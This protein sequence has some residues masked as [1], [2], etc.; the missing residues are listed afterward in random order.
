MCSS[1]AA[2]AA[3]L[4]HVV[5]LRET[6]RP[7]LS[8]VPYRREV[9]IATHGSGGPCQHKHCPPPACLSTRARWYVLCTRWWWIWWSW[10]GT[11][12]ADC[13]GDGSGDGGGGG[14]G[15]GSDGMMV[16]VV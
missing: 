7:A 4:P 16:A 13:G 12:S 11:W 3:L 5:A 15:D 1:S 6:A 2:V 8:L 10:Y 9:L 14:D